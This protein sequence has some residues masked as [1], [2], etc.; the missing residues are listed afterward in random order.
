MDSGAQPRLEDFPFHYRDTI[1]FSDTDKF[2]HVSN[3]TFATY[4]E[5][6]RSN[7]THGGNDDIADSGCHFVLAR[8]EIDY[9]GQINWPGEIH[10]GLRI[11]AIGK[12]SVSVEQALFQND[13]IKARAKSVLVQI[14]QKT[15]I[16]R[17]LSERA[18]RKLFPNSESHIVAP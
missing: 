12:S 17:S 3:A 2:G 6:G 5:T 15:G 9:L 18:R 4:L 14:Y 10:S 13:V 11:F 7:L 16:P 1:R 8:T